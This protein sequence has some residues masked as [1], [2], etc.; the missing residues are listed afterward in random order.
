VFWTALLMGAAILWVAHRVLT[1]TRSVRGRRRSGFLRDYATLFANLRFSAFVLQSGFCSGTFFAIVA[2]S[3]FLMEDT[4]GRSATAYG[5]YFFLFPAGYFAGNL[6]SGR[7]SGR[8]SI[9]AMVLAGAALNLLGMASQAALI[10]IVGLSPAVIFFPTFFVTFS[11]GLALP[12]GQAGAIQLMPELAG[13]AAG[14]GVFTQMFLSALFAQIYGWA[15][16]GTPLPM[17]ET[18]AVAAV[19]SLVTGAIPFLQTRRGRV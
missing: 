18:A 15:A 1:E 9:E 17:I 12:N 2:A 16:N 8:V 5:L 19:L 13:T 14:A 6:V 3:P 10:L 11:Q 7:I 4:L